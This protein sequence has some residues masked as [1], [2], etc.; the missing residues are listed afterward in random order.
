MI[1][2][3]IN[4]CTLICALVNTIL[5]LESLVTS[6]SP[7]PMLKYMGILCLCMILYFG[8]EDKKRV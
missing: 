1:R 7:K 6:L 8:T 3:I 4:I 2:K 5:L